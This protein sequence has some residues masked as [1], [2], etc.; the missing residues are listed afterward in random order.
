MQDEENAQYRRLIEQA[1]NDLAHAPGRFHRRLFVYA[2]L[3]SLWVWFGLLV[4]GGLTGWL[5]W[6]F[7]QAHKAD[8]DN[9]GTFLGF[10]CGVGVFLLGYMRKFFVR[11]PYP[12]GLPIERHEAPQLFE[13]IGELR[14]QVGGPKI[15]RVWLVDGP[16]ASMYSRPAFGLFGPL[17]HH[18]VVGISLLAGINTAHCRAVLAHELAHCGGNGNGLYFRFQMAHGRWSMIAQS[19]RAGVLMFFLK[20]YMMRLAAHGVV[21]SRR[22]ERQADQQSGRQATVR[23]S[24]DALIRTYLIDYFVNRTYWPKVFERAAEL[25]TPPSD[26]ISS[27]LKRIGEGEAEAVAE[28]AISRALRDQTGYDDSHPCLS[29]RLAEL[30]WPSP[31]TPVSAFEDVGSLIPPLPQRNALTELIDPVARDV[32]ISRMDQLWVHF[33]APE[34]VVRHTDAERARDELSRAAPDAA[35]GDDADALMHQAQLHVDVHGV[36]KALPHL[37]RVIARDPKHP[38]ANY[39]IGE[40]LIRQQDSAGV[41]MLECALDGDPRLLLPAAEQLYDYYRGEGDLDTAETYRQRAEAHQ[42]VIAQAEAEVAGLS[43]NTK[44]ATPELTD[45]QRQRLRDGFARTP[46]LKCAYICRIPLKS[47]P[48]LR[49]YL[50][51]IETSAPWHGLRSNKREAMLC[52]ALIANLAFDEPFI[53]YPL[54][55][56]EWLGKKMRK[57]DGAKIYQRANR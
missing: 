22:L 14:R 44:L 19:G 47:M 23:E 8:G 12:E 49:Y 36:E 33:L 52:Q 37:E 6:Q 30:G 57:I 53:V 38:R 3:G 56:V 2:W 9:A 4:L 45:H 31:E 55:Q 20:W 16:V 24:G 46:D 10:G 51:A 15:S 28:T 50:I 42:K 35:T 29:E 54:S 48:D 5:F 26:L 34:W 11:A 25:V 39:L 32:I 21:L 7:W 13:L 18:L 1:E 17:K 40:H 27:L 41:A 43:T